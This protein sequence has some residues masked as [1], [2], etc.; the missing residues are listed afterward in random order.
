[1][2]RGALRLISLAV[3][4]AL[5]FAVVACGGSDTV[6][7]SASPSPSGQAQSDR[8]LQAWPQA[9][10]AVKEVADD[11]VL[12]SVGTGGLALADVPESWSYTYFSPRTKRTYVV[13]VEDGA[14]QP[15][16]DMG[17]GKTDMEA[18]AVIDIESINVG[19]AKAVTLAR[20]FGAVPKNVMVSGMFAETPGG[21]ESGIKTGVWTITFASG[22]D[23]ADAVV[24]SVDMISGEVT[25]AKK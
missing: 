17:K 13:L 2:V 24:F 10:E 11:A 7:S 20:E 3:L 4:L 22:T 6:G 19:A 1:M 25:A 21:A 9:Q 23:L 16:F 5:A 8:V 12:L 18:R 14:A 15:A